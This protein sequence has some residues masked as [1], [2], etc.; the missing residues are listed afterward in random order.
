LVERSDADDD[1]RKI[2]YHALIDV[3]KRVFEWVSQVSWREY[4]FLP[5]R[6]EREREERYKTKKSSFGFDD[7]LQKYNS[8]FNRDIPWR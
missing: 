5:N 8:F 2:V 4:F 3:M 1:Y 7:D 6:G